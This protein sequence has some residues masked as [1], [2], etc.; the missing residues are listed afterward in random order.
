MKYSHPTEVTVDV[1]PKLLVRTPELD[2]I[3]AVLTG[4]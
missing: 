2:D 4:G 1:Q 3:E